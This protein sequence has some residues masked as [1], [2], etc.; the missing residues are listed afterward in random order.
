MVSHPMLPSDA[1]PA[2]SW[3]QALPGHALTCVFGGH[4]RDVFCGRVARDLDFLVSGVSAD[5]FDPA[6]FV[7]RPHPEV[8]RYGLVDPAFG[9]H[10]IMVATQT[11]NA[12]TSLLNSL[13]SRDL[14]IHT[15]GIVLGTGETLDPTGLGLGDLESRVL[16]MTSPAIF[17]ADANRILRLARLS[18]ALEPFGYTLD[19]D[20]LLT[21]KMCE[22]NW[23]GSGL[24]RLRR[25]WA[26]I[27][28]DPARD[29]IET[30]LQQ[31][32]H[33]DSLTGWLQTARSSLPRPARHKP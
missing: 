22:P 28:T 12:R 4:V 11:G 18:V 7:A 15:V 14:T 23:D 5:D 8:L 17:D 2:P 24:E 13:A 33:L 10:E 9:E 26:L 16:R 6:V 21:A 30:R 29:V 31:W 20:T 3:H 19:L 25:Q 27:E 32:G 1:F